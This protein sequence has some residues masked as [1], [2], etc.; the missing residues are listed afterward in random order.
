MNQSAAAIPLTSLQ[1]P[2]TRYNTST[3]TAVPG[4]PA[5]ASRG[6]WPLPQIRET[7]ASSSS[8]AMIPKLAFQTIQAV[9]ASIRAR[10]S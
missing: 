1:C 9:E 2:E 5:L 10:L 3:S 6:S 8:A 7:P 4:L